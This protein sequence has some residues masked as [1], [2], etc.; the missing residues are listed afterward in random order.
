MPT[1]RLLALNPGPGRAPE[2]SLGRGEITVG[3][4]V[5]NDL[6]IGGGG[7]SR[8]H[9]V[10]RYRKGRYELRELNS[11]NGTFVNNRR[12]TSLALLQ[13][14]DEIRF[15]GARFAF[16]N[17][18]HASA[19]ARIEPRFVRRRI[20]VRAGAELL[21]IFFVVGF[22]LAEYLIN[23]E[24]LNRQV[25]ELIG[26]ASSTLAKMVL[27]PAPPSTAA[28]TPVVQSK[29]ARQSNAPQVSSGATAS[30]AATEPDWLARVNYYRAM[31][32]LPP[33]NEDRAL[34]AGDW[35]HARY[36]VENY[37]NIIRN[38]GQLGARMHSEEQT[39][40][41]YSREGIAAARNSDVYEGCGRSTPVSQVDGWMTG[42]FHRLSI[43]NP[44]LGAVGYGRFEKDRC[45][46]A[47]LD[48]HLR[49][50]PS[51]ETRELAVVFP[52]NGA[53]IP[54]RGFDGREWPPPLTSCPGYVAPVGLPITL[55]GVGQRFVAL[56][57]HSVTTN[58][59]PIEHCA[60][61]SASYRNPD[62]PEQSLASLILEEFG[63]VVLIPREPLK[64]G[65]TYQVSITTGGKS[66]NWSFT[67]GD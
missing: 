25:R 60:F 8:R 57:A 30:S 34:S 9:A 28:A 39:N 29:A 63:A 61:D 46:S 67:I 15:G 54:M 17:R 31:A 14:G 32:K 19:V 38:G 7:V 1:A 37:A 18:K 20:G 56:E 33:V 51:S 3:S 53:T 35:S 2:L 16:L 41:W 24:H 23:R 4:E 6:T 55:Q 5:G 43:L 36:L 58:G 44:N 59:K 62:G 27:T 22:A 12:I 66:F 21:A 50:P 64:I 11:T 47:A 40:S 13:D 65:M 42:P 10:I 45:W 49:R 52:P 26:P 48:L